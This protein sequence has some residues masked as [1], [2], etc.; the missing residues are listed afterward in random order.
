MMQPFEGEQRIHLLTPLKA[1]V[2]G[3]TED[4]PRFCE[5][6]QKIERRLFIT[7]SFVRSIQRKSHAAIPEYLVDFKTFR[8]DDYFHKL[9]ELN[10]LMLLELKKSEDFLSKTWYLKLMVTLPRKVLEGVPKRLQPNIISCA[11]NIISLQITQCISRTIC[12]L[13][14]VLKDPLRFPQLSLSVIVSN[15]VIMMNPTVDDVFL[16]FSQ[17]L[18]TIYFKWASTITPR[19]RQMDSS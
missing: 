12:H 16:S 14:Q 6:K 10:I 9:E 3:K 18:S 15:Q 2:G 4:Y 5:R 1:D 11:S 7:H 17:L 8:K 19:Q 13:K